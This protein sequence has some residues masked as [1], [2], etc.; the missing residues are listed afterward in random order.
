LLQGESKVTRFPAWAALA[1][2]CLLAVACQTPDTTTL[3]NTVANQD[4][5]IEAQQSEINRLAARNAELEQSNRELEA[6]VNKVEA[7]DEALEEA[8]AEL[9]E[10]VRQ[11][12]E[13]FQ[14][15]SDIAFERTP[16]GFAFVLRESVLFA[17]GSADLTDDGRAAI[18]RVADALRGGQA[19]ISIEGHTDDVPVS[20]AETL[21]KF[22]LGNIEL[23]AHRALSV[24]EFLV[25]D[26]KLAESRVAVVG[27]GQHRPRVPNDSERNRWRNRRVEI[28]VAEE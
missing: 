24:W 17:K 8:K 9:S 23:S 27:F 2:L 15:D 4:R 1:A 16:D 28:R 25:K 12:Q 26:G 13:R 20:K 3:E 14:G 6:Q 21:E 11:I 19:P 18:Q 10:Q 22:P 7:S 5:T